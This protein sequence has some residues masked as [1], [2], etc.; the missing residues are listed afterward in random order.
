MKRSLLDRPSTKKKSRKTRAE[1]YLIQ[2][3]AYGPEPEFDRE[4]TRV[5][6]ATALTWYNNMADRSDRQGWAVEGLHALG[7]GELAS[8]VDKLRDRLVNPTG[9][10]V[11]R[12]LS[13]GA[14]LPK[15]VVDKAI[16]RLEQCTRLQADDEETGDDEPAPVKPTVD[17]GRER[18]G[19]VAEFLEQKLFDRTHVGFDVYGY[20]KANAYPTSLTSRLAESFSGLEQEY[21]L[22]VEGT[23][24]QVNEGY[25]HRTKRELREDLAYVRDIA[26]ACSRYSSNEKK[27]K[28]PRKTKPVKL[29]KKVKHAVYCK[30]AHGV[31][32]VEPAGIVGA[33]EVWLLNARYRNL[34]VLRGDRLDLNR[35]TIVG[36]DP[37]RSTTK[38]VRGGQLKK[39]LEDVTKGGKPTLARIMDGITSV[40]KDE[41]RN[42]L[43]EDTVILRVRRES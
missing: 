25:R 27:L 5:E 20:L 31:A 35:R 2:R 37:A 4:P 28:A 34:T 39:V 14:K 40:A 6:L 43:N 26:E 22:A 21:V 23:D 1:G 12:L 36:F 24:A 32:S 3:N 13:R 29:E 11:L 19:A 38:K 33:Q 10:H 30:E 9:A 8:R 15:D 42:R 41:P 18:V 7:H 16:S 17:R